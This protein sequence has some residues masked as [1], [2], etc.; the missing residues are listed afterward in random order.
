MFTNR[1]L[2]YLRSQPLG[3]IATVAADGQPDVAAVGFGVDDH[4]VITVGGVELAASRK[5]RNILEGET[6]VAFI[7]DDLESV[8]PWRPRGIRIY[9]RAELIGAS[10][11]TNGHQRF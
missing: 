2:A 11:V 10:A 4:G 5:G 3:R 9:G 6:R 7:V 8:R 1:E